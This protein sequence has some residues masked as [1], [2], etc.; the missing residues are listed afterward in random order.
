M[1]TRT[2]HAP[3]TFSWVDLTTKDSDSAKAFYGAL[4]GWEFED[5]PI[6]EEAGGGVYSMC[7]VGG[8][9]VAAISPTTHDFPPH[10]N[11][12]V[13]V[14]S[15]DETAAKAKE[16]G[17]TAIEEPFDVMEAGRMALLRDPT[18]AMLCVWEPRD[19]IGAGRVN[20]PG[21][22][23]WNELHTPDPDKALE[24]YSG[25]FGWGS[26]HMEMEGGPGYA[27]IKL[28]E[29]S[30][31]GVMTTQEGE[32]PHW[33]PYFTVESREDA[34]DKVNNGGGRAYVRMDMPQGKIAVFSD[35]AGA[36]FAVWEGEVQ[37]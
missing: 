9:N 12:Y 30:N 37:D 16:L 31:G 4:F 14:A 6:P 29:R 35:P 21:C 13:T 11:S 34:T 26:E 23:T 22:L 18:G 32:P 25:L 19:A 24:F 7:K 2:E 15:A 8:E 33:L 20:D 3:G 36:P 27:V 10:W 5:N 28:G 1:G 17:G